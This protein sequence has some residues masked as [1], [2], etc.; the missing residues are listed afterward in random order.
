MKVCQPYHRRQVLFPLVAILVRRIAKNDIEHFPQHGQ[1]TRGGFPLNRHGVPASRVKTKSDGVV[2]RAGAAAGVTI[3]E[4]NAC[5][6]PGQRL[7]TEIA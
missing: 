5:R 4:N 3:G 7:E 2:A 6:A 1:S